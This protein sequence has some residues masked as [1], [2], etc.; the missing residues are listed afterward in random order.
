M[1]TAGEYVPGSVMRVE[2]S[3]GG[4]AVH[5]KR[6]RCLYHQHHL[7]VLDTVRGTLVDHRQ[8]LVHPIG[9][10]VANANNEVM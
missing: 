8:Y 3:R 5:H 7:E 1:T 4:I 9:P 6:W 10:C 2:Y